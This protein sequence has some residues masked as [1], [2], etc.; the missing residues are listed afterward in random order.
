M[1]EK[2]TLVPQVVCFQMLEFKTSAEVSKSI[3]TRI[4]VINTS[5]SKSTLVQREPFLTMFYTVSI[6]RYQNKF[7]C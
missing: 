7:L 3:Q 6:A 1:E 5:F 2:N 4:L